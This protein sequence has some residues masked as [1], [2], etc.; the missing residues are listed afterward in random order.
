MR[1]QLLSEVQPS[2]T[3]AKAL[4]SCAFLDVAYFSFYVKLQS[5]ACRRFVSWGVLHAGVPVTKTAWMSSCST[6]YW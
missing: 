3:S 2:V 4:S 6:S 1:V 5:A